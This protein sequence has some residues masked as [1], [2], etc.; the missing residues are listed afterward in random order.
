MGQKT[1]FHIILRK[2][3]DFKSDRS[4]V[5]LILVAFLIVPFLILLGMAVDVGRLLVVKN[6]LITA[7]DAATLDL[8]KNPTLTDATGETNLVNA[9]VNADFP[10]QSGMTF[11]QPIVTRSANNMTV[12]VTVAA[13]I[14]TYFA[15]V[16]GVDTLTTTIH[17]QATAAQNYLEVVL[18]LDNTGSMAQTASSTDTTSK[19]DALKTAATDLTN[20]LFGSNATS[21]YV[22]IG[23]APFTMAVNVGTTYRGAS[24]IDNSN[25]SWTDTSGKTVTPMS[26]E[27]IAVP[28]GTG[29]ITFGDQLYTATGKKYSSLQWKGCVRQRNEPYDV[30]EDT[31]V[32]GNP[33]TLFTPFFAPDEP[34]AY[35]TQTSGQGKNKKTTYADSCSSGSSSQSTFFNNYL[36]DQTCWQ[37]SGDFATDQRC[38]TKYTSSPVAI[39]YWIQ[40]GNGP[41]LECPDKEILRLTNVKQSVLDEISGMTANGGTVLPTGLMWGWHLLS[42]IGPFGD[43]VPYANAQTVK[44][45]VMVTDGKNDVAGGS[46]SPNDSVFSAYGYGSGTH[47]HDSKNPSLTPEQVLDNKFSTLCSNIKAITDQYGNPRILLY[48]IGLGSGTDVNTSLLQSCATTYYTNT[49]SSQLITTFQNIALGL[50]KLRLSQ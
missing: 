25:N 37:T 21:D 4:G 31:P 17:S 16:I 5:V 50:N 13:T 42:P 18:V 3:A 15:Q 47:L 46:Y 35:T 8:A 34:D 43:G 30:Q 10:L 39:N 7:V 29:L 38:V 23:V 22:K 14:K 40:N 49:T 32:S 44:A 36:C 6:R 1:M 19:I 33:Y 45:I 12:D 26:Q 9:F 28:A 41:N 11:S 48:V 20:I 2:F 24:W 27:N